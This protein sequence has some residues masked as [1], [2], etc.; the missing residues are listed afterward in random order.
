M[1]LAAMLVA[2]LSSCSVVEGAS[3][4]GE[5]TL[6]VCNGDG[7][8]TPLKDTP[9]VKRLAKHDVTCT[10][11]CT[12]E[13]DRIITKCTY[14]SDGTIKKWTHSL[15]DHALI[16][17]VRVQRSEKVRKRVKKKYDQDDNVKKIVRTWRNKINDRKWRVIVTTSRDEEQHGQRTKECQKTKKRKNGQW[18]PWSSKPCN[19]KPKWA[20][21][22]E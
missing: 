3:L 8:Y 12:R 19:K 1:F 10:Q 11:E 7:N 22:E 6:D 17:K 16:K 18:K 21:I 20:T 14:H 13:E 4:R 15:T 2:A 5:T 9:T